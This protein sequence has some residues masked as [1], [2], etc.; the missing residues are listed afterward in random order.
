MYNVLN[1]YRVV[2]NH[3]YQCHSYKRY[4]IEYLIEDHEKLI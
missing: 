2:I 3:C 1:S 4:D